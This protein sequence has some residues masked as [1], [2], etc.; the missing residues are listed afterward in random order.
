MRFPK[1]PIIAAMLAVFVTA[2]SA[3]DTKTFPD[4]TFTHLPEIRLAVSDV[5]TTSTFKSSFDLPRVENEMPV[6]PE[7]VVRGWA[8]DRLSATGEG[9]GIATYTVTDARV[10][11]SALETDATL[12][13]WFTDEQAVRY[14]VNLA[15]TLDIDD[16]GA[17]ASG[18]AEASAHHS[19]TVPE[20][21]TLN[22]REQALF[23]MISK[24]ASDLDRALEA[25]IRQHL[26]GWVR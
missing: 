25:N 7:K 1:S 23:D 5:V 8:G 26:P 22:D 19:I 9:T 14:D 21:A 11:A 6:I 24:T 17:S 20:G 18:N 4:I 10:T 13:D 2:C 3:P 15:A 12:K 16:P